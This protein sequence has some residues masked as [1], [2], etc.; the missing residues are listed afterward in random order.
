[1]VRVAGG[2][3][4]APGFLLSWAD[5][6]SVRVIVA[7]FA[8]LWFPIVFLAIWIAAFVYWIVV[9]VEVAKI[10]DPQFRAA[11]SEKIVWLLIVILGGIIGSLVWRFAKRDEVF[12]RAG[13]VPPPPPGWYPEAGSGTLRWWDGV[14]WTDVRHFP[15][16]PS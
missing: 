13:V 2:F 12:R 10:P 4:G 9:I 7:P 5:A 15:P 6:R 16:P 14:R 11:G 1:V 8:L 3:S